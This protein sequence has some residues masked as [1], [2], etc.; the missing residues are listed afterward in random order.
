MA[1]ISYKG[2]EINFLDTPGFDDSRMKPAE[3]LLKIGGYLA[4][5]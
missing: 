5:K 4:D 2:H 1:S 3:H